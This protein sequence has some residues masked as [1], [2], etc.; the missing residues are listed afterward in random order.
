MI[1]ADRMPTQ[2]EWLDA[3]KR[4]RNANKVARRKYWATASYAFLAGWVIGQWE[5]LNH[6]T[7]VMAS[8][9]LVFFGLL[10]LAEMLELI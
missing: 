6:E 2:A 4:L 1:T 7:A 9:G 10:Y 5:S 3:C 8:V